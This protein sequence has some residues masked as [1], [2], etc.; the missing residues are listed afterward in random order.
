M[1][2]LNVKNKKL[3]LNKVGSNKLNPYVSSE[4]KLHISK[5]IKT[6]EQFKNLF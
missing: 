1:L 6:Y 2:T 4:I 3:F 5:L